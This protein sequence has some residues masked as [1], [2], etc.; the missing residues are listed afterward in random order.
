MNISLIALTVA[1]SFGRSP[2]IAGQSLH[3]HFF[4]IKLISSAFSHSFST[5]LYSR[6]FSNF[7]D[8]ILLDR[9]Q[10][11]NILDSAVK[12][13]TDDE[14]VKDKTFSKT[15]SNDGKYSSL[16]VSQCLFLK[17]SSD[18]NGG[19]INIGSDKS[20]TKLTISDTGFYQ[21]KANGKGDAFYCQTGS[22]TCK[23]SCI[24]ECRN[25]AFFASE[26]SDS[27]F[28]QF[29]ISHSKLDSEISKSAN[30]LKLSNLN[31]SKNTGTIII[32]ATC[33]QPTVEKCDFYMNVGDNLLK[34]TGK[35]S[36]MEISN[37]NFAKNSFTKSIISLGSN[38]CC[39]LSFSHFIDDLSATFTDQKT[40][41]TRCVFSES[42]EKVKEKFSQD[43]FINRFT[44]EFEKTQTSTNKFAETGNCWNKIPK[45]REP[46][47]FNRNTIIAAGGAAVLV[48]G[49]LLIICRV[50]RKR[51]F[52][53]QMPLIYTM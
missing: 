48:I 20:E 22:I 14:N 46:I 17:C 29:F 19:G 39:E 40:T 15:Y 5:I 18:K 25:N 38:T 33:S 36:T 1:G 10:F 44:N 47:E 7:H 37:C 31:L 32:S 51:G 11:K 4:D 41:V 35:Y 27:L 9:S 49:L 52:T 13:R 45:T 2:L 28:D 6:Q 16:E 12:L 43:S 30:S 23:Q 21:C 8:S 24:D 50:C 34:F 42:E 53:D 26:N 3:S